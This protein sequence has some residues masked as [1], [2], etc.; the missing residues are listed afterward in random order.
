MDRLRI[1]GGRALKGEIAIGGRVV[2]NVP[3]KDRDIAMV[4]QNY[5]LYPHMTVHDNMA[6]IG[7]RP[8]DRCIRL[9]ARRESLSAIPAPSQNARRS[10]TPEQYTSILLR[11]WVEKTGAVLANPDT[12]SV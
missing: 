8:A 7:P 12:A 11:A 4:F 5:A 1:R 9:R 10:S 2:N 6:W 3:P